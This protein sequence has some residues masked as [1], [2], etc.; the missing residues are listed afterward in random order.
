[1]SKQV[2]DSAPG[3][4]FSHVYDQRG[5]PTEDSE[6][7]RHRIGATIDSREL[8]LDRD[9]GSAIIQSAAH[10]D[11]YRQATGNIAPVTARP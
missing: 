8:V 2:P 5:E 7:M 9:V 1:M 4:R 6:L 11:E 3:A 10:C